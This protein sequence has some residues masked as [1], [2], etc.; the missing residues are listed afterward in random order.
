LGAS[1]LYTGSG[2][3]GVLGGNSATG[4]NAD[5]VVIFNPANGSPTTYY[6]RTNINATTTVAC[7]IGQCGWRSTGSTSA[8]QSGVG[9]PLAGGFFILRRP[10]TNFTWTV[11]QPFVQ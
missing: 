8:D 9:L 7:P 2:V 4:A 10:L 11:A 1:G 6:F 3:T 5:N